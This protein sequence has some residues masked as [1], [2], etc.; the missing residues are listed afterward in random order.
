M[1]DDIT[2]DFSW[3]IS[4]TLYKSSLIA[5]W[6]SSQLISIQLLLYLIESQ[7]LHYWVTMYR[8]YFFYLVLLK[9]QY[10]LI[11]SE[12]FHIFLYDIIF[13]INIKQFVLI[14]FSL[15]R[16][17]VELLDTV[18]QRPSKIFYKTLWI[19]TSLYPC[20]CGVSFVSNKYKAIIHVD[21]IFFATIEYSC[22]TSFLR[23]FVKLCIFISLYSLYTCLIFYLMKFIM[24]CK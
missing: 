15:L 13:L 19:F 8:H 9:I 20:T 5:L 21:N 7:F 14:T 22:A 1:I 17:V 24:R 11:E 6:I 12:T 4:Y 10:L 23:F 2:W 16:T 3:Y 18:V